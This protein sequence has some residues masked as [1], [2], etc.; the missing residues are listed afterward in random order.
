M[1]KRF[2]LNLISCSLFLT[3]QI[4]LKTWPT[5]SYIPLLVGHTFRI[6]TVT[7]GEVELELSQDSL[8][9]SYELAIEL[10]VS[11]QTAIILSKGREININCE[12]KRKKMKL[13]LLR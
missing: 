6:Q 11:C 13:L 9:L 7:G 12:L 1:A 8:D 4:P 2:F 10:T 3:L 5:L